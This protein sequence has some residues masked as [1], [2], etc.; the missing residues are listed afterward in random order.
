MIFYYKRMIDEGNID[1]VLKILERELPTWKAPVVELIVKRGRR[2]PFEILVSAL[3]SYRT[4]DE[5]TY[6]ASKRILKIAPNPKRMLELSEEEISKLIY[7][8]GFY[9]VKARRL[10]EISKILVEKYGGEVPNSMEELLKLPGIGRKAANIIMNRAFKVPSISV[11]THVHRISNRWGFVNTK[12]PEETE[13]ELR[14][15]LPPEWWSEYN[16]ILVAFGQTICRPLNPKCE[17]CPIK[18]YCPQIGVRK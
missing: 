3:L 18:D 16:K 14:R 7:P 17:M 9:R 11:D 5:V 6:E 15:K 12:R 2:T 10:R 1:K 8:V 4:K 13:R